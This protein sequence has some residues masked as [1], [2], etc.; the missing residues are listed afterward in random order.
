M[1]KIQKIVLLGL[2][3]SGKS[4]LGNQLASALGFGFIDLDAQIESREQTKISTIFSERGEAY[5]RKIEHEVL[6]D[7]LNQEH[8]SF[9][10][11]LG[12][13]T[14]CFFDHMDLINAHAISVFLDTPLQT[15]AQRLSTDEVAKRPLFAGSNHGELIL[16]LKSLLAERIYFYEQAQFKIDSADITVE[17]LTALLFDQLARN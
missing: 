4:H 6:L 3:G 10:L 2:P 13:G 15:I 8:Q 17:Q 16:K 1:N 11:A 14:P 9:V 5:F 7:V 12:G